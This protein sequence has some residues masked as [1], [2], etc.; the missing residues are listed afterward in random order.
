M[1]P[2]TAPDPTPI[3]DLLDGIHGADG[4]ETHAL[5][6]G[7]LLDLEDALA[8]ALA[9][10]EAVEAKRTSGVLEVPPLMPDVPQELDEEP[11]EDAWPRQPEIRGMPTMGSA[12]ARTKLTEQVRDLTLKLSDE[13]HKHERDQKQADQLMADLSVTRKR[14]HKLGSEHD[15]L[16]KRLQ[17]AE[18]DLPD[19]GARNVLNA[20]LG[21][22]DHV[23][24]VFGHLAKRESLS[25]EGREAMNMLETQWQRAFG[26][27]QVTP[28]D[29]V[30]EQYDAQVHEYIAQAPSD[31][32]V[33]QIIRQVG[34]GYL[35]GGKLL[36]SARVV[37]SGGLTPPVVESLEP[38][39]L[40]DE[41]DDRDADQ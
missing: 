39:M 8:E 3:T 21:P 14:Y 18:L 10:V 32:P 28:F 19:Q 29:A 35:L 20:L 2:F 26:V 12:D 16:R 30:G 41:M 23:H 17:R 38:D 4:A 15:E 27:L 36:R 24:E 25:A 5:P 40:E 7:G 13:R 22:L 1:S 37:V 34:R 9:A 31:A 6:P 33:G 11:S